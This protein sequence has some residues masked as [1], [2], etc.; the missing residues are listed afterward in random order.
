MSLLYRKS[1]RGNSEGFVLPTV[2]ILVL[3]L[4][5][6]LVLILILILVL[7]LVLISVLIIHFSTSMMRNAAAILLALFQDLSFGLNIVDMINPKIIAAVIP[8]A[9]ARR[10]PVKIPRNPL[11]L[12]DSFTPLA[13]V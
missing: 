8:P 5:L 4:G 10:P 3:I 6:F 13:S 12:I 7:V 11:W 2:F 9:L 1:L